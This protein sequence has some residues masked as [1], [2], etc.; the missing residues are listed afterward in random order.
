MSTFYLNVVKPFFI[1]VFDYGQS[2]YI[3]SITLELRFL[4]VWNVIGGY[5]F[6]Y[7]SMW[8]TYLVKLHTISST[9]VRMSD[10]V[11]LVNHSKNNL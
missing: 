2:L 9:E 5:G 6:V 8:L 7:M 3:T 1:T 11:Y 4:R 10:T